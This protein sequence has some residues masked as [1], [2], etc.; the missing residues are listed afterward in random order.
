MTSEFS[1]TCSKYFDVEIR[2]SEDDEICDTGQVGEIMVRPK[3]PYGFMSGY[4]GMPEKTLESWRNLWFHTG[5]ACSFDEKGRMHYFDRIK[6]CI[7][8]RGENISAFELEQ[9]IN[10]YE[11]IIECAAIGVKTEESGGEDEVLVC[12]VKEKNSEIEL[13]SFLS[14][15]K[16]NLPRF[17]IPKFVRFVDS[18]IKTG[19]GKLS[20]V[21]IREEGLTSDSLLLDPSFKKPVNK[22]Q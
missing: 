13:D 15:C 11:C 10:A 5:D 2:N 8:R 3:I 18:I 19:S 9:V 16:K 14:Y 12:I 1:I 22:I 17:A 6:D 7:R 4:I 20:K 21:K